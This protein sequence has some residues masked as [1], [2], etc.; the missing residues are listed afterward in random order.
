MFNWSISKSFDIAEVLVHNE[1]EGNSGRTTPD[2]AL[3][4]DSWDN[5]TKISMPM[6]SN[7]QHNDSVIQNSSPIQSIITAHETIPQMTSENRSP[8]STPSLLKGRGKI[9]GVG[10]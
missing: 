8:P 3:Y 4:W 10:Y 9:Q 2:L 6:S 7:I 5:A 1:K